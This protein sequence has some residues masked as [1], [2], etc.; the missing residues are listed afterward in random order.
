MAQGPGECPAPGCAPA[1][2]LCPQPL[3][4]AALQWAGYLGKQRLFPDP[5]V[6]VHV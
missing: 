3:G 1:A 2:A 4:K 6:Y 5:N